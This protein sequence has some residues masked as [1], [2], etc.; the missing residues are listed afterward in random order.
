MWELLIMKLK[1]LNAYV[2]QDS[3]YSNVLNDRQIKEM[4]LMKLFVNAIGY[5]TF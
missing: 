3:M 4:N 5:S 1:T 2:K